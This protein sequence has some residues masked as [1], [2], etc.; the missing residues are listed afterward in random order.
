MRVTRKTASTA[1][2]ILMTRRL[3]PKRR[4]SGHVSDDGY[5][6]KP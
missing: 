1:M 3:P 4:L 6:R 2:R 5:N